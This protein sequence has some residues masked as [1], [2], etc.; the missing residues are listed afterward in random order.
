[1]GYVYIVSNYTRTVVYVGVTGNLPRRLYEHRNELIVGFSRRY[2]TR[3][4]V[5][6][7]QYSNMLDAIRRE[8]QLKKWGRDK[9]D[10][11]IRSFN[12]TLKDLSADWM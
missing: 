1:M 4:L 11:L 8:K 9:K 5:H 7:E 2:H 3:Y 12:P 6:V 10:A